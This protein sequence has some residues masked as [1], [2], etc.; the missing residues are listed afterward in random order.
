[1]PTGVPVGEPLAPA[2]AAAFA[3]LS[4]EAGGGACTVH[5]RDAG[6]ASTLPAASVART[7]NV[8]APT[9][10]PLK[11]RGDVHAPHT[12]PSSRHSNVAASLAPNVK[13]AVVAVTVPDGP[14][15]IVVSGAVVSAG[16][17]T[18]HARDAGDASTLPAASVART[19]NVCAPT[20]SPPKSRG[21][22]HAPHTPP[23]SRHS[24][25]AASLA[26]NV[27][28][29][30]VAVTVPDGPPVIVVSGA[31]VSTVQVRDAGDASTLP[32]ASVARASNVCVPAATETAEGEVHA[33]HA[34]PSRRHWNVEP[35]SVEVNANEAVV[36]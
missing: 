1:M 23:S 26:P 9:A 29:A 5:V 18:V 16:A 22:V 12:P 14:P 35:L 21:D 34:A 10:S 3:K 30:V 11:S 8:C 36:R 2:S 32:A 27:K 6:D 13:L 25:V 20:A 31:V 24:N 17:A 15:V 7:S 4:F 19:S 33:A 28:L